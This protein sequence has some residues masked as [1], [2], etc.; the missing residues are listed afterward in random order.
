MSIYS[1]IMARPLDEKRR[2]AILM[3]AMKV[4]AEHGLLAPTSLVSKT[5][6]ISEGSLFTYVPTKDELLAAL[7]V[8]IRREAA[9]AINDGFPV[10]A[11]IRE[12]LQ[13]VFVR[14]VSWGVENREARR[15]L[16]HL[17]LARAV[18]PQL[19]A[20]T[21]RL[22]SEVDRIQSDALEQKRLH[23]PPE[24][25]GPAIA[26]LADMTV[27]LI[28]QQPGAAKKFEAAG[29]QMLWGALNSRPE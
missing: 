20:E 2:S 5:A 6:K 26:A 10:K 3:A 17:N 27:T 12:R 4:F 18:T 9:A 29:F 22:Y 21:Q 28:A 19:R 14:F 24:V 11:G 23:L 13:H 25:A 16:A 15:A 1:F 7:Y 8:R